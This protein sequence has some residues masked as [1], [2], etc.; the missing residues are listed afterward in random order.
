MECSAILDLL[1]L[2]TL[3]KPQAVKLV[4]AGTSG[5]D[6]QDVA[7]NRLGNV[8]AHDYDDGSVGAD[9]NQAASFVG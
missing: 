3:A 5:R 2:Q 4:S 9:D 8:N 6:A 1:L 7:L